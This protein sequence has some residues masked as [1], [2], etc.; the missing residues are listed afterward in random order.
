[1]LLCKSQT[2]GYEIKLTT[3]AMFCAS[4]A[5]LVI[6]KWLRLTAPETRA[7]FV[8]FVV[9]PITVLQPRASLRK[10]GNEEQLSERLVMKDSWYSPQTLCFLFSGKAE[11][12]VGSNLGPLLAW[13]RVFSVL[14][15]RWFGL[16]LT[17]E[18]SNMDVLS[19]HWAFLSP[20]LTH[21]KI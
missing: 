11:F 4:K 9:R 8:R 18:F 17:S 20:P 14:L 6:L 5:A 12:L 3:T 13:T 10:L 15:T 1:M 19:F 2:F 16:S 7:F 21:S